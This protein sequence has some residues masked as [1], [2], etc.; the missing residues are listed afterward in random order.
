VLGVADP[1]LLRRH[2]VKPEDPAAAAAR[3]TARLRQQGAEVVVLLAPVERAAARRLA[4]GS[5]A[6]FVVVGANPGMGMVR[7]D[8]VDGSFVVAP[9]EELQMIGR[10]DLVLRINRA[11][12][13]RWWTPGASRRASWSERRCAGAWSNWTPSWPAG[14]SKR[15]APAIPHFSRPASRARRG[16]PPAGE[17]GR[18]VRRAGHRIVLHQ[19]ADPAAAGAAP[20]P[21][22]AA[23]MRKL[24]QQVGAAN[25]RKAAP[26]PPASPDRAPS[27]ATR[28]AQVPQAGH[29][30]LATTVHAGAWKTIVDGGKTGITIA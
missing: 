26:P 4:R 24:D 8:P 29:G 18:G 30:V 12:G 20:D 10:I 7:A 13:P 6:D 16:C 14:R 15:A 2:G 11:S 21:R 25:L 23:A 1:A 28:A 5:G 27:P 22:L 3:E 17:P 9:A 19:P